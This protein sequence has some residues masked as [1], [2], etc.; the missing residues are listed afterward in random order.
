MA[1]RCSSQSTAEEQEVLG[2]SES[3]FRHIL[4][5]ARSLMAQRHGGCAMKAR[6]KGGC[7]G[8][9]GCW[10]WAPNRPTVVRSPSGHDPAHQQPPIDLG[11]QPS[12]QR[13]MSQVHPESHHEIGRQIAQAAVARRA[14]KELDDL[15]ADELDRHAGRADLRRIAHQARFDQRLKGLVEIELPRVGGDPHLLEGIRV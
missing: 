5:Q 15:G 9:Q 8:F 11:L 7:G 10:R 1:C 2:V 14:G 4:S 6:R 3:K 13:Q 12:H